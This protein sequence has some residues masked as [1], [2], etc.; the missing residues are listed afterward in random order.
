MCS[1]SVSACVVLPLMPLR[2]VPEHAL[3]DALAVHVIRRHRGGLRVGPIDEVHEY[4]S[5]V[6]LE[7]RG[8]RPEAGAGVSIE[9]DALSGVLVV[10]L[11]A[12]EAARAVVG[13]VD[14]LVRRELQHLGRRVG[15]CK[16]VE[17]DRGTHVTELLVD[18]EALLEELVVELEFAKMRG[19]I[20][21]VH[22]EVPGRRVRNEQRNLAHSQ[23]HSYISW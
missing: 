10:D 8:Q 20:L 21:L 13:L 2:K 19:V 18:E 15:S 4:A 23:R 17:S 7:V 22:N 1:V 16:N 5:K 9:V 11:L 14:R 12:R 6:R 3:V